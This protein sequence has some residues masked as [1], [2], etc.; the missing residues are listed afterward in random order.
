MPARVRAAIT[1]KRS[2]RPTSNCLP[3]R[4]R[5]TI[6]RLTVLSSML[7]TPISCGGSSS[8]SLEAW[9]LGSGFAPS[10]R[11]SLTTLRSAELGTGMS[12]TA[13]AQ[14]L[15]RLSVFMIWP[16]GMVYI[17][18]SWVRSFVTRRVTSTTVPIASLLE[19]RVSCTR[20]PNPYCF[21]VMMK[22]PLSRSCTTRW[23]PKP[24]A[25][26]EHR[27]RR[28]QRADRNIQHVGHLDRHHD[29]QQRDGQVGDHRGNSLA[30]L[31]ALQTDQGIAFLEAVVD[32]P[33]DPSGQP[34]DEAGA[35]HPANQQQA[36]PESPSEDP[37]ADGAVPEAVPLVGQPEGSQVSLRHL[38]CCASGFPP[39]G[40]R[41]CPHPGRSSDCR[42]R[43]R[44]A[45]L[46]IW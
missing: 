12:T 6:R 15:D 40:I 45:V 43:S 38:V 17:S 22:N 25:A 35:E 11:T 13:R 19:P 26:P 37:V 33:A 8:R 9:I 14:S 34:A 5:A 7:S 23:A 4:V 2:R 18:P 16:L 29:R 30:V 32:A 1:C 28:H 42:P 10:C 36:D 44:F 21:S 39:P 3:G 46:T 27:R 31:G 20:S 41:R 24:S